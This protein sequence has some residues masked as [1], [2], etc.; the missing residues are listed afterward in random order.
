MTTYM[1]FPYLI[2]HVFH[3]PS[4]TIIMAHDAVTEE[5]ITKHYMGFNL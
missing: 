4:V 3:L 5:S 1:Y 2:Y